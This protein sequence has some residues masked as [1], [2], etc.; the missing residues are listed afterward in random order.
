MRR[1]LDKMS[2]KRTFLVVGNNE[3]TLRVIYENIKVKCKN[4]AM[5]IHAC[6]CNLT[7][8]PDSSIHVKPIGDETK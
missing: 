6:K 7:K 2:E 4:C 3:T 1:G 8:S 5:L